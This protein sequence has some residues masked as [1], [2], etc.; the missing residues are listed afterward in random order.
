[1]GLV[2][3][4]LIIILG[5]TIF[6]IYGQNEND[7]NIDSNSSFAEN[8]SETSSE[9]LNGDSRFLVVCNGDKPGDIIFMTLIEFRIYSEKIIV[10]PLSED[11]AVGDST[12]GDYYA[13]GGITTLK[14]AV[15]STRNC[16]IDRYVLMDEDGFTDIIDTMGKVTVN[17]QEEFTYL[18]SDKAYNVKTG[19]NELESP[20]LYSYVKKIAEKSSD[21]KALADIFCTIINTYMSKVAAE[22][23]LEYF[24]DLCNF[25]TTDVSISDYYSC[26]A[27]INHLVSSEALCVPYYEG[28]Q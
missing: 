4:F 21:T 9:L 25:V 26:S 28:E 10:I 22:D 12:Y 2:L 24:E 16:V 11:T 18:S 20:M 1:M 19:E 5:I 17:V 3:L 23:A 6:K 13:Y 7:N 27:D 15:E 8:L 14:K